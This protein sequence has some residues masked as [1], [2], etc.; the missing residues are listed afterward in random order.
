MT[1]HELELTV[2]NLPFRQLKIFRSW[3]EEFDAEK[4]DE[5]FKKDVDSGKLDSLAK[6]ALKDFAKG[7][8][9]PF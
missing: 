6:T 2:S 4:W 8:C 5:Q 3:F 1:I 7:K 9:A